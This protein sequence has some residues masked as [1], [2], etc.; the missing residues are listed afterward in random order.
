MSRCTFSPRAEKDF[1]GI[2]AFITKDNPDA[3]RKFVDRLQ[4]SCEALAIHPLMGQRMVSRGNLYRVFS[5]HKYAVVYR[6]ISDGVEIVRVIHGA[7]DIDR[8][9]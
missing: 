3:A 9:F 5:V 2:F 6:T 8:L 1:D 4:A 7:R